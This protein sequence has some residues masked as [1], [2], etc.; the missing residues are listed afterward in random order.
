MQGVIGACE[1]N[2][3]AGCLPPFLA[4]ADPLVTP[5]NAQV[6]LPYQ[7]VILPAQNLKRR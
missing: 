3:P 6:A 1:M 5:R 4:R 2:W 7:C